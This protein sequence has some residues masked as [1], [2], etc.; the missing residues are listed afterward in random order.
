MPS[1]ARPV[2]VLLSKPV[3][4]MA[5]NSTLHSKLLSHDGFYYCSDLPYALGTLYLCTALKPLHKLV[6]FIVEVLW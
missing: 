3:P 4:A 5:D 1:S 2:E 6:F